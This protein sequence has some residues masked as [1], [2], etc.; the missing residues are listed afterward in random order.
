MS[1]RPFTTKLFSFI[2]Y[3]HNEK[4][5]MVSRSDL[6]KKLKYASTYEEWLAVG[7]EL[8]KRDGNED[9][10]RDERSDE[11]NYDL[12][13]TRLVELRNARKEKNTQLVLSLL[14]ITLTRSFGNLNNMRLYRFAYAGT[15]YLINDYLNEVRQCLEYVNFTGDLNSQEKLNE[16][17][18]L[19]LTLGNTA[20]ILS[21]GGTFGMNHIGVL[22]AL[23]AEDLVPRIVCGSSAGAIVAAA[24]CVRT[25]EEQMLLIHQFH[26]GD[27]SVFNEPSLPYESMW[28]QLKRFLTR[29][30]FLDIQYLTRVMKKLVG[31][32]TFQEAWERSGYIL[33][34]TVSYEGLYDMPKL[35]NYITAPNVLVWSAVV[36]TCSVPLLFQHATVWERDPITK[37]LVPFT[38]GDKPVWMDGSVDG[39]IPHARLAEMFHVNHFIVSQVN[40]H[41]VPFIFDPN[42][43][44]RLERTAK[45]CVDLIAQECSLTLGLLS[46]MG[47]L[48]TLCTK[49]Q[50]AILQ[51]YSGDI[52]ILPALDWRNVKKVVRNPTP[53]FLL[54]ASARG[55]RGTWP[56]ISAIRNQCSLEFMLNDLINQLVREQAEHP[57]MLMQ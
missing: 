6:L 53:S 30:S 21:G 46:E 13:R 49:L 19:K 43:T 36:A 29:G 22:Q 5:S 57:A 3:L 51:K 26:T 15:K 20:L 7:S 25:Y 42:S 56:K 32:F 31:D 18:N 35:L 44:S 10:R 50:S 41:I 55:K 33:N 9:W 11:Y 38:A 12:I 52:T 28:T 39:D 24:A 27:L 37:A 40:F 2:P 48:P 14:R 16:F 4:R 45:K 17:I 34:I 8:D 54:D 1:S 23:L 47:I